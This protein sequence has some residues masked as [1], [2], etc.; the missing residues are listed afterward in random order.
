MTASSTLEKNQAGEEAPSCQS[1]RGIV[2]KA[3][4]LSTA[5]MKDNFH[6][7]PRDGAYTVIQRNFGASKGPQVHDDFIQSASWKRS[8]RHM[9]TNR[10]MKSNQSYRRYANVF[11]ALYKM[12][13]TGESG[14]NHA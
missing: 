8:F 4:H 1:T 7:Q 6:G 5:L 13:G 3:D 12:T 9:R 11:Q 2:N 10:A 14:P